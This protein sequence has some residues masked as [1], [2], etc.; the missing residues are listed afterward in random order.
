M[1]LTDAEKAEARATDPRAARGDRP[2]RRA[3]AGTARPAARRAA[4]PAPRRRRGQPTT[5]PT[6]TCRAADDARTRRGGIRARTRRS[7]PRPTTSSSTGVRV[8]RG[9]AGAA[10]ARARGAPTRRICSC[11]GGPRPSRRCCSTS[12]AQQHLG[13]TPDDDAELAEIAALARPIPVLRARTKWSRCDDAA[14]AL[15]AGVGNIFLSD[16]AFGCE[17]VRA[18]AGTTDARG[19]RGRRLRHPR[20]AS[21][22]P[23]ARRLRPARAHRR[24]AARPARRA[25]CRCSRS[26]STRSSAAGAVADGEAPLVDAHGMEPASILAMLA[27]LGGQVARVLVVGL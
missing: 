22:L 27:S 26:S 17:V 13:V 11:A 18:M 23:A 12:T 19:R 5:I 21:G 2:G 7:T 10:A 24:G 9:S 16:D 4:L 25:R 1:T 15:V 6:P 3:A 8:A 20:R 14:G